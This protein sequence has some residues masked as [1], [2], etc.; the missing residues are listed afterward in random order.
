MKVRHHW[1]ENFLPV[2]LP[3]LPKAEQGRV[4]LQDIKLGSKTVLKVGEVIT[5]DLSEKLAV[6]LTKDQLRN[7]A[8]VLK[9]IRQ[10][11]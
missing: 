8:T 9:K 11:L 3:V 5:P 7:A 6:G 10:K 1:F 2:Y 4:S